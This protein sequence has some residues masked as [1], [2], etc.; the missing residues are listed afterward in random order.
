MAERSD[1]IENQARDGASERSESS[2]GEEIEAPPSTQGLNR[3]NGQ[4]ELERLGVVL[5]LK[6]GFVGSILS[7]F[8]VLKGHLRR[9]YGILSRF[10]VNLSGKVDFITHSGQGCFFCADSLAFKQKKFN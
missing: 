7:K 10:R 9:N 4:S 5:Q 2:V 8:P 6:R 3:E 1:V